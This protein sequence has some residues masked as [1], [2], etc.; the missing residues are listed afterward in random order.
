LAFCISEEAL[1][2]GRV[3]LVPR[4]GGGPDRFIEIEGPPDLVVEVVSDRSVERDTQ[5]LYR[6]YF[7]AG[8]P[9]YWLV[10]ARSEALFFRIHA[11]GV[12]GFEPAES[13]EKGYQ[14]SEVLG[15]WYSLKRRRNRSGRV[16]Y[17]LD[18]R[19]E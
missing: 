3:R 9:E 10:D 8:V 17:R 2:T 15:R 1:A 11:R 6:D 19:N 12:E 7:R 13:D 4:A 14:R 18:S 5:A 16:T